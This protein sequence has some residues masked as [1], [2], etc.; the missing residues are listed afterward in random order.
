M[1]RVKK[2]KIFLICFISG[3]LAGLLI[4]ISV[5]NI[6]ISYRIDMYFN[7]IAYLESIIEDKDLRLEKLEKSI[8]NNNYII[9]SIEVIL[10]YEEDKI[11]EADRIEIEKEIREKYNMLLGK[12]VKDIDSDMVIQI[13]DKRIFRMSEK[14]YTLNIDR[15]ILT[16][17]LRIW[18]AV[19][20]LEE[21]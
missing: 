21:I 13:L 11:N 5:F 3:M 15:L 19:N 14:Q 12:E 8:N 17:T 18:V 9:K 16:D 6:L 7:K 10:L 1:D 2:S 20:L 4:G